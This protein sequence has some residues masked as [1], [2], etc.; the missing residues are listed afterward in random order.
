MMATLTLRVDD[1]IGRL[2]PGLRADLVRLTDDLEVAEVWTR[3]D[4]GFRR[5]TPLRNSRALNKKATM[6]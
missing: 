4:V 6:T 1:R 5:W 2:K 3:A